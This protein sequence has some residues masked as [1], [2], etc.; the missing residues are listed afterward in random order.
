VDAFGAAMRA[1][2][3]VGFRAMARAAAE[4]L[5][6]ALPLVDVP[7]LLIHGERDERAPRYVADD[8]H[9]SIPRSRLVVLAD[10]GH[11]CNIEAAE[12]FNRE[13]RTF[14]REHQDG[15]HEDD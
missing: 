6:G 15:A 10:A 14:L 9:A 7:V 11:V 5:R 2:H 4:N 3:P 13:M 8:L 12:Q 1:F